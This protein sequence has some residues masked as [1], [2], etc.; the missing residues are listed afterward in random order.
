MTPDRPVDNAPYHSIAHGGLTVEGWSRAAVQSYWRVPEL[1]I[2]FDLG[3]QPWDFMGTATWFVSHT[4]LDHIAALPVYVARRR[5]M[6]MDPPVVYVPAES[7]DDVKKLMA[8]MHRLDRG[9]QLADV[10]GLTAGDEIELSREH[11]VTVFN[12][13]HTIPSR[14]FVVWERRN[15]LKD[16]YVGLAGD[17]IRDLK[18]SGVAITREVR[19]PLLAYTG[20][21]APAGLD[22]CPACFDAKI[23]ITEMSFVRAA[24]RRDKIHKF[25]HMHLDDFVERADRFKNELIVAAHFSTRYHPNEV[26]KIL[27]NKLPA[28]LKAKL[29]VWV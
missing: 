17:K 16:E 5:M 7:L 9:R 12:T 11:V 25:G 14:G 26:R 24:H 22:A 8:I 2:G 13:V 23:L 4:H 27:D 20:D 19:I 28:E 3:A 21:T 6:K 10:R 1:K 29:K 15:K 18:L